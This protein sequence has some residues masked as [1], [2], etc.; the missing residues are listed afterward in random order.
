VLAGEPWAVCFYLKCQA[1]DRGYIERTEHV[2][3]SSDPELDEAI[4]AEIARLTT[5]RLSPN[6]RRPVDRPPGADTPGSL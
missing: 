5:P 4:N 2:G 1:K 3:R 6:G